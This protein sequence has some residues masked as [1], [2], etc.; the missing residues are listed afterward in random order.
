MGDD[1]E[2]YSLS[3]W[4]DFARRVTPAA[5]NG[6]MQKHLDDC[7]RCR[8]VVKGFESVAEFARRESSY[9]PSDDKVRIAQSYFAVMKMAA[10]SSK[11]LVFGRLSFDSSHTAAAEGFRAMQEAPRQLLYVSGKTAVDLRI[12]A[13]P[14]SNAIVLAGQVLCSHKPPSDLEAIQ[15]SIL[16]GAE[17]V[18]TTATNQFGEFYMTLRSTKHLQLVFELQTG[19]LAVQVPES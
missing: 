2:H 11:Q 17:T 15:V 3:Q 5:Q 16:S 13:D 1:V 9:T 8:S 10:T 12:E 19:T 6:Q 18:A 4:I 7:Q 14:S